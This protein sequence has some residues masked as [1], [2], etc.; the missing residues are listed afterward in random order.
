MWGCD[1]YVCENQSCLYLKVDCFQPDVDTGGHCNDQGFRYT[2]KIVNKAPFAAWDVRRHFSR[3][4]NN[5][6]LSGHC[7]QDRLTTWRKW[8]P[9]YDPTSGECCPAVRV[10]VRG[11]FTGCLR[12]FQHFGVS[13]SSHTGG[14]CPTLSQYRTS[15]TDLH[16]AFRN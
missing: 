14:F 4:V 7:R 15:F 5:S 10:S 8:A 1:V 3:M 11:V 16:P 12:R 9:Y 6:Q 2:D 13:R